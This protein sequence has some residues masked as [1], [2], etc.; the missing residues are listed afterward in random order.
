MNK[1]TTFSD[2]KLN[3]KYYYLKHESGL[4]IF[5]IPK[6]MTLK[7][8]LLG[9]KFGSVYEEG[10]TVD[11]RIINFPSGI[12]HFL[13]HKLFSNENGVDA[14]EVLASLG[15][16]ANAYTSNNK[17]VYMFSCTDNLENSLAELIKFVCNPYFTKENVKSECGII[18]QEIKMCI[19][20]PYDVVSQNL[21]T[22]LFGD[23]KLSNDVLGTEKSIAQI[24]NKTLYECY[25]SFYRY[26]NMALVVCG[27]IDENSVFRAVDENLPKRKEQNAPILPTLAYESDAVSPYIEK[28]MPVSQPIFE[29][30]IKDDFPSEIPSERLKRDVA[31]TILG[32]ML[33]SRAG[34]LYNEL[35]EG[36]FINESYSYGYSITRDIAFHSI[37]GEGENPT[38]VLEKIKS[39]IKKTKEIG[40]CERDFVRCKRVMMAEFIRDFD[41]VD[42]VANSLL[43]IFF[44]GS[45]IFEYRKIIEGVTF[46]DVCECLE[47]YFD[48]KRF[49]LSVI[50]NDF[51]VKQ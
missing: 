50:K 28:N 48:D 19:D 22:A 38:L 3:E 37:Y 13:E 25:D 16:D 10:A 7:T 44:D 6:K 27:D 46:A 36:G 51:T 35:F 15:A 30:G 9:V 14:T 1:F 31:M 32:E 23:C 2:E 26:S 4:D 12:A 24:S 20:S 41:S 11:G 42:D 45:N 49:A 47:N 43:N 8:A 33:F 40:L 5:V 21:L 39:Y 29:I 34:D 18:A 17:T